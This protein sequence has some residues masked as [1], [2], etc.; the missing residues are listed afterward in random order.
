MSCASNTL[1]TGGF[2]VLFVACDPCYKRGMD[3]RLLGPLEVWDRG[4]P[5]ELTRP[6][7]RAL[8]AF[9]LLRAGAP[10]T[11][12]ALIDA[13]WGERAPPTARAAL[14]NYVAQL[15]RVLGPGLLESRTGGYV[16]NAGPEQ[17][18]LGR[19]ERLVAE[20]RDVEGQERA[21]KL[22]EALALWQGPPLADLAFEPFAA[23]EISR[24]EDLR[25]S[26]FEDLIDAQLALGAGPELLD[27]L[28]A[29]IAEHPFRE[30]LRA[31]QML[32]LYRDGRQA[33]AL[34]AYQETRRALVDGLGIEPGSALRE[35]EAAILR[36][37]SSLEV[38][39]RSRKRGPAP[40]E[41]R[42]KVV[43][44]LFADLACPDTLDPELLRKT[45][46]DALARMQVV[47]ERHGATVEQRGVDE[48]M[49]VFGVPRSHEDDPLRAARAAQELRSEVAGLSQ[50][51]LQSGRGRIELRVGIATGQVLAEADETTYGFVSGPAVTLAKR[52]LQAAG[53][54]EV[55]LGPK[56]I[57]L[58]GG[59][60]VSEPSADGR[61]GAGLLVD[62]VE[63]VQTPVRHPE[64][65]LVGRAAELGRLHE[66]LA[67]V[68]GEGTCR[69]FLLVGEAGIGKTR[70]VR[71]F[72]TELDG[73]AM[74]LVGH[75]VSYGRGAT[76]V[77]LAEMIDAIRARRELAELLAGSEH[78]ELIAARLADLTG[79]KEAP[80]SGGETFWAARRLFEAL[81]G[82]HPL[83]LVFEDLHW[84]EPSLLDLLDYLAKHVAGV[85]VLL[86]GLA[87]PELLEVRAGWA[88]GDSIALAPLSPEDG[89]ALIENA[90]EVPAAL[91]GRV[92]SAAG[93]NPLFIEQLLAHAKETG[94]TES[95]PLS[96]EALL[97]SRLDRLEAGELSVLQ[98]AAVVGR[99]FRAG[100]VVQLVAEREASSVHRHLL[101]VSRK[102]LLEASPGEETFRFRHVL[103][104]DAAYATLPKAQ[105]AEL[106]ERFAHWLASQ[107]TGSDELIGFH[108][109]QA[110]DYLVELGR[111]DRTTG[112]LATEAGERLS[113]AGLRAAK[114][115]D[116][117]AASGLLT[118]AS[119]LL[120]DA[121]VA[122]RDLLTELGLVVWRQGELADAQQLFE[123][124]IE[125]AAAQR[126]R[127]GELRART[128]LEYLNL[129][130]AE[131]GA[132]AQVLAL[133]AEAIPL[134]EQARDDRALGRLWFTLASVS[135]GFFCRYRQSSDE[136]ERALEY[137]RRSDWPLVPC[138]Q[139]IAAALYYGPTPVPEATDRC[140]SLLQDADRGG[141]AQVLVFQAGLEA[142]AGRFDD[143]RACAAETRQIYEDLAWTVYVVTM[144]APISADIEL[145]A[146]NSVEAERILSESCR[147]LEAWG[148]KGQLATQAS[149]LAEAVYAQGR[150]D[151]AIRW[152]ATAQAYSANYDIGAQFLWRAVRG[153]ALARQGAIDEGEKLAREAAA[154]AA[155]TDSVSQHAHVQFDLAEVLRMSG[156]D[157]EAAE[158]SEE[159]IRLLEEKGNVAARHRAEALLA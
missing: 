100:A 30:R 31:Q 37:D 45:S 10:V 80:A 125:T 112:A 46:M 7:L 15:R 83:V 62:L 108:F 134:L 154:L 47:L 149:R 153:K 42:R 66:A 78:A 151:E 18:D 79:E 123:R 88:E 11:N 141:T 119:S 72:V 6:K 71:E 38:P 23:H 26:A 76:Y 14:Q 59:A 85:P 25:T 102:G 116:M 133:A 1:L 24:L 4:R 126:D 48:V 139:E 113:G 104:R 16:L 27:R 91:R 39:R 41:Q 28:E 158:A 138:L 146:G 144:H 110:H 40:A 135:G 69:R 21:A 60:V 75:C 159:A 128:E 130:R 157:G 87:R 89:A 74:V 34:V 56:T 94:E 96:L 99:E 52:I 156:R 49:A 67:G 61:H 148:V 22:S 51:L 8:L 122:R 33:D 2:Q 43:T 35:L 143:A 97:A 101:E 147:T 145:L 115:G 103:I 82:E 132:S 32:A 92:L 44:I 118:R 81:A 84:A 150:D 120:D 106:H 136:A 50:A 53:P 36:Q 13:L 17:I 117:P 124:S 63:G 19:F 57:W 70:L 86:L 155:Q 55:L 20:S 152:S 137:F 77:P 114:R 68:V 29:L 9:L 131:E 142:M 93:G 109:E 54:D 73:A 111:D 121:E 5:L 140:R 127:R 95:M 65:P 58:L 12:D 98:R 105:R 64:A 129:A 3:F 107:G 90:G